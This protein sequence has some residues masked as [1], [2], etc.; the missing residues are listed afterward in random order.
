KWQA[1]IEAMHNA[2]PG[3]QVTVDMSFLGTLDEILRLSRF[4]SELSAYLKLQGL[5]SS[6]VDDDQKWTNFLT[7][8][9]SVIEDCPLKCVSKGL[10]YAD[11]VVLKVIDVRPELA[12]NTSGYH[13][14]IEWSWISKITGIPSVNQQ[15]Y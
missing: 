5:D 12:T 10:Q 8:Y 14:V 7:Y 4:R 11:E 1:L 15:F 2:A 9:A 3:Q 6:I 13:L